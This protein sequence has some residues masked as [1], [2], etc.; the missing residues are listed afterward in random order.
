VILPPLTSGVPAQYCGAAARGLNAQGDVAGWG[1]EPNAVE[2]CPYHALLWKAGEQGYVDLHSYVPTGVLSSRAEAISSSPLVEIVGWDTAIARPLLWRESGASWSCVIL[3]PADESLF[4]EPVCPGVSLFE[5]WDVNK[6]GWIIA[7]GSKVNPLSEL[8]ETHLFLLVPAPVCA[9]DADRNGF[10]NFADLLLILSTWG[11][12]ESE[13]CEIPC[14]GDL[15]GLNGVD[16]QDLLIVLNGWTDSEGCLGTVV[17]P[18]TTVAECIEK[19]G[20][21]PIVLAACIEASMN[22]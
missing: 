10:V 16:F 19:F 17:G 1:A 9:G 7:W 15:D 13:S 18:P 11:P 20:F 21:D 22:N 6:W 8:A 12:C 14:L 4:N 3:D 2:D 5:A